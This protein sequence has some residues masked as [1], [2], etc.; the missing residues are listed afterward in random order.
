MKVNVYERNA[1]MVPTHEMHH[2][3]PGSRRIYKADKTADMRN[4]TRTNSINSNGSG[5]D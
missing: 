4:N 2:T 1:D 5:S 3:T